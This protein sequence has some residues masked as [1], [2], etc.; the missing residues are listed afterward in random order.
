MNGPGT[1]VRW[2]M[3]LG[4]VCLVLGLAFAAVFNPFFIHAALD[5]AG[6]AAILGLDR[7]TTHAVSD[8][9]IAEMLVGP[10]TFAFAATPGGPRFYDAAEAAHLRDAATLLHLFGGLVLVG[11]LGLLL[12]LGPWRREPRAWRAVRA[13]ALGLAAAFAALALFFALAFDTAFTLFHEIFFPQGNWAFDSATERMVQLYPTPFWELTSMALATGTLVVSV[14]L[15]LIA[16][17]RLHA[18]RRDRLARAQA[19]EEDASSPAL[20]QGTGR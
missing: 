15:A 5:A 20:V 9:T 18:L 7:Q 13:A 17:W 8:R 19:A 11:V 16:T 4:T 10:G 12:T 1:G 2:V 3:A 6:S 14:L